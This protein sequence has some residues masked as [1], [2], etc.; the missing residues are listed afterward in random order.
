[1]PGEVATSMA[2][3]AASRSGDRVQRVV[4]N[5]NRSNRWPGGVIPYTINGAAST[6]VTTAI[7]MIEDQTPA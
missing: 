6:V 7:D 1:M 2:K 4:V 5:D 3:L